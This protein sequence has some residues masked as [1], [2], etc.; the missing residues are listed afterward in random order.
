MLLPFSLLYGL[1]MEI[2]NRFYEWGVFKVNS[3]FVPVISVGNLTAGGT[4]KT[5]FTIFLAQKL[6][7][8]FSQ[9]AVISRGYRRKSKGLLAVSD[10][11]QIL[12][13]ADMAGD[14]PYLVAKRLPWAVVIVAEKRG[15]GV[16][17]ALNKYGA[18]CIILDD[19]FQHRKV[20][21]D[22]DIVLINAAEASCW[23]FPLPGG[24]LRE[25]SRNIKRAGI[26]V[27]TNVSGD[28]KSIPHTTHIPV[29]TAQ[30]QL[31]NIIDLNLQIAGK[32]DNL[33]NQNCAVFAGI[34]H[35]R[36]FYNSLQFIGIKPIFFK[37]F[38][39][40]YDY[41]LDDLKKISADGLK[42]SCRVL[43]CTEKDLVKISQ[44]KGVN[45]LLSGAG[46]TLAAVSMELQ[47]DNEE[48][49]LKI[50]RSYIDK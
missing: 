36:N 14:E 44:L 17:E 29:F 30:S 8:D 42:N 40:H 21:R 4:G 12:C 16:D 28:V 38:T 27:Q 24:T 9:I 48:N 33:K 26:V 32:L 37:S 6:R 43:V 34:A 47:I 5:P 1:V 41:R 3:F 46:Q 23:N 20:K 50:I 39:D 18:D 45:A 13:D 31:K 2:R 11:R 15:S 49:M 22:L 7:N 35:P 25:F 19:A 10:G